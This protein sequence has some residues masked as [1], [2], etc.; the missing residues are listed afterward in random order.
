MAVVAL[1]GVCKR[2]D[3]TETLS[4]LDLTLA[5][6]AFTVLVGP[7]GCGKTTTLRLIAGLEQVSAGRILIAGRDVTALE[8]RVRNVAMVFQNYALYAHLNVFENMAFGLRARRLPAAEI[9]RRVREAARM[10]DIDALLARKPRALSGGQQQRVAIGRAVVRN[11][12]VFLFDEPLSNLD[13]KLR[14]S[15][16]T[17][18][19][20]LH[21]ALRTTTLYVTHDQEEAMTM[22]D[23]IVVMDRGVIQQTGR[24]QEIFRQPANLQVAGLVGSP[25]MN[26]LEGRLNAGGFTCAG[27]LIPLAGALAPDRAVTLGVRPDDIYRPGFLPGDREV[28]GPVARVAVI[29]Y[30]GARAIA[31]LAAG[32]VEFKAVF[33]E[34]QLNGLEE[35][36]SIPVVFDRRRLHLFDTATG[37]RLEARL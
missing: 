21:R 37:R 15:M 1:E 7:S 18:L 12:T 13:A 28:P 14:V 34:R 27:L 26:L 32:A 5:D 10:L 30:L 20:K 23:R 2:F 31:T 25:P 29:E 36:S 35:G 33:D 6:G 24:P 22:G 16:R 17:E 4:G 19:L 11:P 8:P 3:H 9:D